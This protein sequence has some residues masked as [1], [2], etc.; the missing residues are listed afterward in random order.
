MEYFIGVPGY[1][2]LAR[3]W[4]CSIIPPTDGAVQHRKAMILTIT[5]TRQPK[6]ERKGLMKASWFYCQP[7]LRKISEIGTRTDEQLSEVL[8][9]RAPG[10]LDGRRSSQHQL[11]V[12][13]RTL[14]DS[15]RVQKIY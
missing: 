8:S 5:Q 10:E 12:D 6:N 11:P 4:S 3:I 1:S 14:I 7:N 13:Q 9:A 2:S 15:V